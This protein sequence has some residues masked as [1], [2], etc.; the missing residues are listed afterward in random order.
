MTRVI[1]LGF[2]S[3]DDTCEREKDW[4]EAGEDAVFIKFI[5]IFLAFL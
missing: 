4:V 3:T 5:I 2:T 1:K